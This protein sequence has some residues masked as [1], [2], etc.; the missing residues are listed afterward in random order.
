MADENNLKEHEREI[1]EKIGA[2]WKAERFLEIESQLAPYVGEMLVALGL[3]QTVKPE[4]P[5]Q[6]FKRYGVF[7]DGPKPEVLVATQLQ[8][9]IFPGIKYQFK[10]VYL[11][12]DDH[13]EW[14]T[15]HLSHCNGPTAKITELICFSLDSL[16]LK[17]IKSTDE[18]NGILMWNGYLPS[19][20]PVEKNCTAVVIGNKAVAKLFDIDEA[21]GITDTRSLYLAVLA[22]ENMD[23]TILNKWHPDGEMNNGDYLN[24]EVFAP[25]EHKVRQIPGSFF[26]HHIFDMYNLKKPGH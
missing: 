12:P 20:F 11:E 1:K 9:G 5:V 14:N 4:V 26:Y 18:K 22:K 13:Q 25:L 10:G 23:P 6:G 16:D 19:N 3:N 24:S 21:A 7:D 8:T 2:G 15:Y 17:V